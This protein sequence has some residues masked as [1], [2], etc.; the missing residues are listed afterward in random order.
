MVTTTSRRRGSL[1][2]WMYRGG[3]P[4][5]LATAVN[6]GWAAAGAHG[7]RPQRLVAME[8]AGRRT[9]RIISPPLMIVD[10]GG[11]RYLVSMLG[12]QSSWVANVRAADGCVVLYR[13]HRRI[14]H[15]REVEAV[16]RPVILRR[17]LQVAP[18]ARAFVPVHRVAPLAEFAAVAHLYPVFQIVDHPVQVTRKLME[19]C[20][21]A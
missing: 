14:V 21:V 13:G 7:W 8:V 15:L 6:R 12:E 20:H 10:H 4:N 5:L 11:E 1:A 16:H 9:G 17:F 18:G 2:R 3:H 19:D